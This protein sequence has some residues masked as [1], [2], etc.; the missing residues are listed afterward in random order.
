MKKGQIVRRM[1]N[2]GIPVGSYMR[3]V[4]V[5]RSN[6]VVA[7]RITYCPDNKGDEVELD[8]K[9]VYVV[10]ICKLVL[11]NTIWDRI[12]T[13]RQH[14][15]IH[16]ICPTWNRM[17]DKEPEMVQLRAF[18]HPQKVMLFGV[19]QI[20]DVWYNRERQLRLDLGERIL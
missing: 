10:R 18:N 12:N 2:D 1:L 6:R 13:D 15:I 11:S 4:R 8:K 14:S 5:T 9:H 7:Q 17:N 20:V 19:D 3:I 16:D